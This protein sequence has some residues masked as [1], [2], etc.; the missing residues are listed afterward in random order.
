MFVYGMSSSLV[1]GLLVRPEPARA[2]H[3]LFAPL[4][5]RQLALP[6]NFRLSLKGLPGTN[7]Q[8]YYENS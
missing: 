1:L 8:A 4:L 5:C 2:K 6:T 3:L 7:A